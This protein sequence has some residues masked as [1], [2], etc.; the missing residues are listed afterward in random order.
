M[1]A[2]PGANIKWVI[3]NG[4]ENGTGVLQSKFALWN[5]IGWPSDAP[6][7][8]FDSQ[9]YDAVQ[10]GTAPYNDLLNLK[11]YVPASVL[12]KFAGKSM[13]ACTTPSGQ[14]ICLRNDTAADVLWVN[15]GLYTQFFGSSASS[16]DLGRNRRRRENAQEA[17]TPATSSGTSATS[18]MTTS[19][20]GATGVRS[21]RSSARTRSRSARTQRRLHRNR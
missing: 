3:Y 10:L 1:K 4:N 11:N 2:H 20:T 9:N 18:S 15:Q 19:S 7:V 21:T 16:D 12:S 13:S 5:R 14:V 8:M 17:A 6:D